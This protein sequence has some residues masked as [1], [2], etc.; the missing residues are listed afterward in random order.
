MTGPDQIPEAALGWHRAGQGAALATVVETWGSAPRPA[1]SQ[2]AISG[3]GEMAGS[4]SGGCVEA[5]VVA[6]ALAA[7]S[8][9][10]PRL[11]A[12]GV[13]DA[14]AFAAGLACGGR[15]RILV[16]PVGAALP[17]ALLAALV[18]D[19]AARLPRA[20]IVDLDRWSRRLA[21]PGPDLAPEFRADR[22][23]I[24]DGRFV[25]IHNPPL[26]IAIVG[27]VHVAQFLAP[28]AR[29]CGHD[30]T[31]IDPRSA[32]ATPD[33]FPGERLRCDWPDIALQTLAPD[34]RTAI[35][36]LS[37]DPKIDDPALAV[38]LRSDAY[39]IGALGSARTHA[40]R[41]DRLAAAGFAADALARIDAPAGLA[42]GA[43]TP[44]EIALSIMAALT[45]TL[46]Q[47]PG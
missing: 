38:A 15:I 19:R 16:E 13:S 9:G 44:A 35:V 36:T 30:P 5:A 25:T 3:R 45:R 11:L 17:E 21:G 8:D 46:R 10:R 6:E 22:S 40:A 26:R 31:L 34:A 7:L 42:I 47:P 20:Y 1:G 2:M 41:L 27:A 37:H 24:V 43:R 14:D 12:Y 32:F 4:V 33:R 23:G 29:A 39:Y 18:A 28:M